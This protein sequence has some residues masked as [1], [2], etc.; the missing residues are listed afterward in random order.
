MKGSPRRKRRSRGCARRPACNMGALRNANSH[1]RYWRYRKKI[2]RPFPLR[3]VPGQWV[4]RFL[5][6]AFRIG[7]GA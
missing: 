4:R 6:E 7:R 1:I 2:G 5:F 3:L